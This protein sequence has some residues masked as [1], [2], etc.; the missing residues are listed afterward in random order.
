MRPPVEVILANRTRS[1]LTEAAFEDPSEKS[2][3]FEFG[4][5]FVNF[6]NQFKVIT[7]CRVKEGQIVEVESRILP[8]GSPEERAVKEFL[9]SWANSLPEARRASLQKVLGLR[10]DEGWLAAH[11]KL[12]EEDQ[13]AYWILELIEHLEKLASAPS[14]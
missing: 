12:P 4:G 10:A 2:L 9:K 13:R 8:Q 1:G 6:E 7:K 14:R 11:D 5:L 3:V